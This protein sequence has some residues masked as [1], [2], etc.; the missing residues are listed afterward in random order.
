M[1]LHVFY[2]HTS[3]KRSTKTN[4][5]QWFSHKNCLMNFISAT[6]NNLLTGSVKLNILFDG[7]Q[8]DLNED[9]CLN[10]LFDLMERDPLLKNIVTIQIFSGG[11]QTSAARFCLDNVKNDIDSG[12]I[13]GDDAIYLLENDYIH[14]AEWFDEINK[15]DFFEVPWDYAAL[16]DHPDKYPNYCKHPDARFNKN[17]STK[18]YCTDTSHWRNTNS[19][20]GSYVVR[21]NIFTR[22][23]WILRLGIY[24]FKLFFILTKIL[25]RRLISP[26]PSLSTHS[27]DTLLAPIIQWERIVSR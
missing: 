1:K 17:N 15:L 14:R 20:C 26:M 13:S 5:P 25:R 7:S 23:H 21:A 10:W 12:K 3:V 18:I 4:R 22:D 24:D 8:D 27:M 19:T 6:Y 2:R 16:Y 9:D 11:D